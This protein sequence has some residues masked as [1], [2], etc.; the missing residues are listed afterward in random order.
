ML[1]LEAG[2]HL[3]SPGHH[4]AR[5]GPART[6]LIRYWTSSSMFQCIRIEVA[7]SP[8]AT[9]ARALLPARRSTRDPPRSA[10]SSSTWD[11]SRASSEVPALPGANTAAGWEGTGPSASSP[12]S[13]M[14]GSEGD[15]GLHDC[16]PPASVFLAYCLIPC[17]P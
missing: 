13:M 2:P 1:E 10:R 5:S 6:S 14:T 7:R 12:M 17:S 3:A 4:V 11:S 8:L 16:Q 15:R 9:P